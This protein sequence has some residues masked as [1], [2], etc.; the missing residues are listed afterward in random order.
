MTDKIEW[1]TVKIEAL[2]GY[3]LPVSITISDQVNQQSGVK[4]DTTPFL[5]LKFLTWPIY[6]A[7]ANLFIDGFIRKTVGKLANEYINPDT[8]FLEVGCGNMEFRKHLPKKLTYN[9]IDI[10]LSDFHLRRVQ[11]DKRVNICL[12]SATKIPLPSSS[13]SLVVSTECF[14]HIENI[15]DALAEIHR[16]AIPSAKLVCSISNGFCYKYQKKGK[17]PNQLH[18]WSFQSFSNLMESL[19]YKLVKGHMCGYWIPMPKWLNRISFHLP[20][21]SRTESLNTNFFFVFEVVK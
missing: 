10:S 6:R 5:L 8:V 3:K 7:V 13:V 21:T 14:G 15:E 19:G 12:A 9:A 16:I 17:H 2:N 1:T 18:L 20:I 11:N 4:I